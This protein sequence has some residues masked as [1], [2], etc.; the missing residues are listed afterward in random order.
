MYSVCTSRSLAYSHSQIDWD[1]SSCHDR[2]CVRPHIDD[3]LDNRKHIYHGI[4]SVLV[5]LRYIFVLIN[6]QL[7]F[8]YSALLVQRSGTNFCHCAPRFCE[9]SECRL[10]SSTW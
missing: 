8:F 2:V 6:V 3:D 9:V 10:L 1:E 5:C 4:D 7:S